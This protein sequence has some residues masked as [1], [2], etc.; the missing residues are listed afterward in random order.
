MS[1]LRRSLI[2]GIVASFGCL[3]AAG[4]AL[5][6]TVTFGFTGGEQTFTVPA[7]VTSLHAVAVGGRGGAGFDNLTLGA[8]GAPGIG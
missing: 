2:G 3:V 1:V 4:P 6:Q 7:G 8:F 5:G